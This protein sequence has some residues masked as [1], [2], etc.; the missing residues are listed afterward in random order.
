MNILVVNDT[1]SIGGA[2]IFSA[3]LAQALH[4]AGHRVWL[5][6]IH[7]RQHIDKPMLAHNA[8]DVPLVTFESKADWFIEKTTSV[9]RRLHIDFNA[10][11]VVVVRHLKQ[12]I[13]KNQI[14]VAHA[15]MFSSDYV[16]SLVKDANTNFTRVASMH[17]THEGF[18]Y[19]YLNGHGFIITNY[20][21]KLNKCLST[22]NGIIYGTDRNIS[23]L[24]EPVVDQNV[25]P[26]ILTQ[27]IYNGFQ[28]QPVSNT[29]TRAQLGI[30]PTDIV[31][32]F[33][34]RG[35]PSKG[36][37]LVI[38]AFKRLNRIDG[39]LILIGDNDY[40]QQ[41]K[42][43]NG[44][45]NI[46][47]VGFQ[48]HANEWINISDVGLLPSTFGESIPTVIVEFLSQNKPMIVTDIAEC[49]NMI[50]TPNGVAGFII[51]ISKDEEGFAN[52][53]YQIDPEQLRVLLAHYFENP[54]LLV[55]QA[56]LAQQ[57]FQQFAMPLCVQRHIDFYH[58]A[59]EHNA[60]GQPSYSASYA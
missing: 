44:Q 46:H 48:I 20:I 32:T 25:A 26:Q 37:P 30:Q 40:V 8:P 34:A 21:D 59:I 6:S 38:E 56:A 45:T 7:N 35:V 54:E 60:A 22:L 5:Y 15:H 16:L 50:T 49:A 18:L 14:E 51:D 1:F 2:E 42:K 43:D 27:R 23:F 9:C 11:E 19:N 36:W 28:Q 24:Q 12:F 55:A 52:E 53:G 17:G 39:H 41:L 57:A 3:R 4:E 10:R 13:K 29:V 58:E 47:F 31:F 33:M